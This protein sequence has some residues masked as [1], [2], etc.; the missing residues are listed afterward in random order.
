[1]SIR[2]FILDTRIARAYDMHN[3]CFEACRSYDTPQDVK[4]AFYN[5]AVKLTT[6]ITRL[7]RLKNKK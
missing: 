7:N 1:M 5:A 6:L 3:G 4:E 2:T